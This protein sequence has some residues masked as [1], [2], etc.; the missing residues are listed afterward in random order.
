MISGQV[1]V[2]LYDNRED[3]V[4]YKKIMRF[5]AGDKVEPVAY[6]FPPGVMHGYKCTQGPMQ[7]I[8]VTS[9]VYDLEDEIRKTDQD[10]NVDFTWQ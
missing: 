2:A 7:I 9:G 8:Y 4:T 10:I 1:K 5:V 6:F 3:S